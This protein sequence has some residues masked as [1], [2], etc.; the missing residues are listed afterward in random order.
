M[1]QVDLFQTV[2][3]L[4]LAWHSSLGRPILES[5]KLENSLVLK[6]SISA[7]S[8]GSSEVKRQVEP[9]LVLCRGASTK[10]KEG[11][12]NKRLKWE[13]ILHYPWHFV[14]KKYLCKRL[15]RQHLNSVLSLSFDSIYQRRKTPWQFCRATDYVSVKCSSK[16]ARKD[17]FSPCAGVLLYLHRIIE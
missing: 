6:S 13:N 17:L 9:V 10:S 4:A 7:G 14:F 2:F 1:V 11:A 3:E 16:I 8:R 15:Q 12:I 5:S